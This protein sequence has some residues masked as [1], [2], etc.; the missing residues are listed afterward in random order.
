MSRFLLLFFVAI[1][2]CALLSIIQDLT[3]FLALSQVS[4]LFRA[5]FLCNQSNTSLSWHDVINQVQRLAWMILSNTTS[6]L[7]TSVESLINNASLAHG[8]ATRTAGRYGGPDAD[9]MLPV[10]TNGSSSYPC[11]DR[12][13]PNSSISLPASPKTAIASLGT[14]E[15]NSASRRIRT[16]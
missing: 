4:F 2:I 9:G 16:R 1:L 11:L 5:L 13:M 8:I 12:C 14:A 6:Q 15:G 7:A 10:I 3:K